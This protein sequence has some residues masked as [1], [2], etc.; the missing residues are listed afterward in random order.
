MRFRRC[1]A[2]AML[3]LLAACSAAAGP[4]AVPVGRAAAAGLRPLTSAN[5]TWVNAWGPRGAAAIAQCPQG[6]RVVAGGSA[7]SD[8]S[9]VGTGVPLSTGTAWS[10]KANSSKSYAQAFASCVSG[11]VFK[12]YFKWKRAPSVNNYAGAQCDAGSTMIFGYG[13]GATGSSWFN[14]GTNTFWVAGG[15]SSRAMCVLAAAGITIGHAWNKSPKPQHVYAG[16]GDA[17]TAVAGSMGNS[18][19][20]GPPVQERPGIVQGHQPPGTM[21]WWTSSNADNELTWVACVRLAP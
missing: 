14:A 15:G 20:R 1:G 19:W 6:D 2:L 3:L 8:G 7:S 18:E 12:T 11:S 5:F 13:P 10:V 16:C 9:F 4:A 21:G 17:A